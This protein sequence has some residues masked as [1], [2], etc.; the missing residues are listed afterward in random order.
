VNVAF[1]FFTVPTVTFQ[2]LYC[3]FVM[4]RGRRKIPHSNVTRHPTADL[5]VQQLRKAFPDTGP[6][7]YAVLDRA[8]K[9]DA[10]VISFLKA[11][12]L[13]PKR[14]CFQAPWQ[15]GRRNGGREVTD[16]SLTI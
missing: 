10:D 6:Y 2:W 9:F 14:T 7:R 1:D 3:Y 12:R 5:V 11:T 4:E 13:K 16:E 15:N 8:S